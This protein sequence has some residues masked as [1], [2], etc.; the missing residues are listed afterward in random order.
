MW[1]RTCVLRFARNWVRATNDPEHDPDD[2]GGD[3]EGGRCLVVLEEKVEAI[4][5]DRD[6]QDLKSKSAKQC[7]NKAACGSVG[8]KGRSASP[9]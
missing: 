8:G 1:H 7:V 6:A 4:P 3:V 9:T 5:H 2:D